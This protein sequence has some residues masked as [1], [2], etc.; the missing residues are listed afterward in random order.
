MAKAFGLYYVRYHSMTRFSEGERRGPGISAFGRP[1]DSFQNA[2]DG[3]VTFASSHVGYD[4]ARMDDDWIP[5][6]GSVKRMLTDRW[7]DYKRY[8]H[9]VMD[10]VRLERCFR[11]RGGYVCIG[12][13]REDAVPLQGSW[14]EWPTRKDKA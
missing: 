2:L 12:E 14:S 4:W 1:Y 10:K 3:L 7:N 9:Q 6:D 13:V 5:E 11:Y 8:R